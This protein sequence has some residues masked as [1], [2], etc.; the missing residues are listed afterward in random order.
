MKKNWQKNFPIFNK[1]WKTIDV[2]YGKNMYCTAG[3]FYIHFIII[4]FLFLKDTSREQKT[5]R[6]YLKIQFTSV[7]T[8]YIIQQ[9]EKS[10]WK[11]KLTV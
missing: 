9:C 4:I 6:N 8:D 11:K 5:F 3:N 2:S 7:C 10:I 1:I